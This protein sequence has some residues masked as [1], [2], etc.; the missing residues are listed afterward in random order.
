ML[1]LGY[2]PPVNHVIKIT[3]RLS[4]QITYPAELLYCG[5]CQLVQ[6]GLVVDKEIL[7]PPQ[8]PYT[9]STTRVLRDN[10]AELYKEV[11]EVVGLMQS[12]LII[13]IGCNDGNLLSNFQEGH[14]VLGVTPEDI[15]KVARERGIQTELAYFDFS[16]AQKILKKYGRAKI[17]TATNVF[18][19]IDNVKD[20][21]NSIKHL[22]QSDGVFITESHYLLPLIQENQYDTIYHEHLRYYSV[23]SLQALLGRANLEVFHVK[24][25]PS[26]GGSIRVYAASPGSYR[27]RE[28]VSRQIEKEHDILTEEELF[29]KFPKRVAT[30]KQDLLRILGEIK[31]SGASIAAIGAPS[32]GTTLANYVGL[33]HQTIDYVCEVAGSQKIGTFLPG[34]KIPIVDETVL[35]ER[36]PEFALLLSWHISE[37][38]IPI[39]RGRGFTGKLIVPLPDISIV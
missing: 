25:I 16:V 18:A 28:T 11:L 34:T 31:Q 7:F 21:L 38:L 30:L 10:F 8:Y 2:I 3:E 19:H 23:Q 36:E 32:R 20:A 5:V 22:L 39:M 9:S 27:V 37:E 12:D 24:E 6:L 29:L 4:Q 13:D 33:D 26:H 15:G 1:S 14:R 35:F 17:V